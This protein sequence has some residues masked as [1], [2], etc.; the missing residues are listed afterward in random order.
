MNFIYPSSSGGLI[1]EFVVS[2]CRTCNREERLTLFPNR[3]VIT[4]A[5][6]YNIG[7]RAEKSV[8]WKTQMF[9]ESN[10][11]GRN[12][13]QTSNNK[14]IIIFLISKEKINMDDVTVTTYADIQHTLQY[15]HSIRVNRSSS[16]M[17]EAILLT[18]FQ[19]TLPAWEL[20]KLFFLV[21]CSSFGAFSPPYSYTFIL[22]D[23]TQ[24]YIV[25]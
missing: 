3:N 14:K 22:A 8:I 16:R 6:I 7:S 24:E 4:L 11:K 2:W 23:M 1:A 25:L 20:F 10:C 21:V 9:S 12:T 5:K 18:W 19:A 13:C 15:S 17:D